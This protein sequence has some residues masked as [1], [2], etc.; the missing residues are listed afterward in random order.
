MGG[1]VYCTLDV[2]DSI[3]QRVSV[4]VMGSS[5]GFNSC[6][7]VQLG[8]GQGMTYFLFGLHVWPLI[9]ADWGDVWV[10]PFFS[11]RAC[12]RE[13]KVIRRR[14]QNQGQSPVLLWGAASLSVYALKLQSQHRYPPSPYRLRSTTQ[15][16]FSLL[17]VFLGFLGTVAHPTWQIICLGVITK[18]QLGRRQ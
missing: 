14:L 1:D 6:D 12:S 15:S 2:W 10:W 3:C 16:R 5:R 8:D 9:R 7:E 18:T 17:V 4:L 13:H 11:Q